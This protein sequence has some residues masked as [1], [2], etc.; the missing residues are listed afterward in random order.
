[1]AT[2]NWPTNPTVGQQY[3]FDG[4]YWVFTS[5]GGWKQLTNAGQISTIFVKLNDYVNS[6]NIVSMPDLTLYQLDYV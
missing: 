4:H 5:A 2:V 3:D 1:M 6:P